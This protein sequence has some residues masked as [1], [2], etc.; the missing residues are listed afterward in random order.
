MEQG[1]QQGSQRPTDEVAI[2]V[3]P[4]LHFLSATSDDDDN[5]HYNCDN[6]DDASKD[7][8]DDDAVNADDDIQRV[9]LM[10]LL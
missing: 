6:Y 5:D 7:D 8:N 3:V 9:R 10:K 4:T 2:N 1:W